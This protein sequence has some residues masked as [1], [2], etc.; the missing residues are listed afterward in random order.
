MSDNLACARVR[1]ALEWL[2]GYDPEDGHG[3]VGVQALDILS[4]FTQPVVLAAFVAGVDQAETGFAIE[5]STGQRQL[6]DATALMLEACGLFER[7]ARHHQGR[8]D[9]AKAA[10][11]HEAERASLDKVL[12]NLLMLSRLKAWLAGEDHYPVSLPAAVERVALIRDL[13]GLECGEE[14]RVLDF[15]GVAMQDEARRIA[16]SLRNRLSNVRPVT[17]GPLADPDVVEG[18]MGSAG[19]TA[20]ARSLSTVKATAFRLQTGDPRFDPTKPLCVNG[21]LF[22]PATEA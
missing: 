8:A 17:T 20:E 12:V 2:S 13:P 14:R 9:E 10:E 15:P 5:R 3:T 11:D 19:M 1:D 18:L 4:M 6:D 7:Y 16:D 22:T 21:Y